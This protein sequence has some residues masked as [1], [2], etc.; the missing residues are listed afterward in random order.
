MTSVIRPSA[1]SSRIG[2]YISVSA[3]VSEPFLRPFSS[4][5]C[6]VSCWWIDHAAGSGRAVG[7]LCLAVATAHEAKQLELLVGNDELIFGI[8]LPRVC[9]ALDF[10]AGN[11]RDDLSDVAHARRLG[12]LRTTT[13]T[14]SAASS[15]T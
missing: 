15:L 1:E 13:T 8:L 9:D 5:S 11:A 2:S 14:R 4:G 6:S 7:R 3:S 10:G 12:D